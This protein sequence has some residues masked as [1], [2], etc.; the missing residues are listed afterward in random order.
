MSHPLAAAIRGVLLDPA[1]AAAIELH[2]RTKAAVL[3]ALFQR[4]DQ[5]YA[6][7]TLRRDDLRL[8]PGQISFPGGRTDP[9]DPDLAHTALR[10][11][12]EEIGLDPDDVELLGAL[13]PASTVVTDFAVYPFVGLIDDRQRFTPEP[14]EVEQVLELPLPALAASYAPRTLMLGDNEFVTDSYSLDGHLVWGATARILGDLLDRLARLA[15][16]LAE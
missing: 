2:G 3:V 13:Q 5:L 10:E 16:V 15:T 12:H 1:D 4:D 14:R 7:L 9:T 11:A 6:V 8:H